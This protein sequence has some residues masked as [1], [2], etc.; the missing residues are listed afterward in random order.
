MIEGLFVC[1]QG[2]A[3]AVADWRLYRY[4]SMVLRNR[5]TRCTQ[6]PLPWKTG[7]GTYDRILYPFPDFVNKE[8]AGIEQIKG[9][10]CSCNSDSVSES[11]TSKQE[12]WGK[13]LSD[14]RTIT[15]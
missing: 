12:H 5:V 4:A 1:M 9:F 14:H 6:W 10:P 15:M 11:L 13:Y 7:T 2:I 3:A 8:K